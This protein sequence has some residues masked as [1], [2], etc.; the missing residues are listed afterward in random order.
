MQ[1]V[2]STI[3]VIVTIKI[4]KVMIWEKQSYEL[5]KTIM[6]GF[7]TQEFKEKSIKSDK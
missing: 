1:T 5:R 7:I 3:R 2:F 4:W 6:F